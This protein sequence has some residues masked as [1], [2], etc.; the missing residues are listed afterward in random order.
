MCIL[1]TKEYNMIMQF[2]SEIKKI[3]SNIISPFS[4]FTLFDNANKTNLFQFG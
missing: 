1:Q 2:N 3:N 4:L